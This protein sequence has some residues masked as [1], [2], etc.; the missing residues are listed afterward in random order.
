ML[1]SEDYPTRLFTQESITL[2]ILV[3]GGAGYIGSHTVLSLL[4]SGND[5]VVLDSLVNSSKESLRRI[6]ALSHIPIKFIQGDVRDR[7]CLDRLFSRYDISAVIHLAGLK[8]V[9]ESMHKPL[10]YY[11]TNVYGA[12]VLC[13]AMQAFGVRRLVFSSS[14]TVYGKDAPVPYRETMPRGLSSSPYGNSK[15]MVEQILEGLCSSDERWSVA[16]LRYFNPIGAH[17]SGMIGEDP[18]G[19][20]NNLMPFIAQVA[21]GRRKELSVFGNDY[22]TEDGSCVRDYFT[23]Y[24]SC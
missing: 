23:C 5:L 14:A 16:M 12:L 2:T 17:E 15:A 19:A 11:D 3:T 6:Q 10:D 22:P 9:G 21:I 1:S 4:Q 7:S 24:G 8:A 18:L 13:Q 20:P